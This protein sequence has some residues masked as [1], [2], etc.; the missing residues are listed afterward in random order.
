[1]RAEDPLFGSLVRK[2]AVA[3][4]TKHGHPGTIAPAGCPSSTRWTGGQ[5]R[6][7]KVIENGIQYVRSKISEGKTIGAPLP[8]TGV[9]RPWSCR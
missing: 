2:V 1:L 9:F 4:F 7:N 6:R 8:E 5:D 3:R